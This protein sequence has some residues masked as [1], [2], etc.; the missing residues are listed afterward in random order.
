MFS[1]DKT[2]FLEH[3]N[4]G[5]YYYPACQTVTTY[6]YSLF[7]LQEFRKRKKDDLYNLSKFCHNSSLV[8]KPKKGR[9]ILWYHHDMDKE[10]FD[11]LPLYQYLNDIGSKGFMIN[12][13]NNILNLIQELGRFKVEYDNSDKSKNCGCD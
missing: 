8:V 9:A 3:A 2:L 13:Q 4:V 1:K 6:Y 12:Y 5:P 7:L 11:K 10:G